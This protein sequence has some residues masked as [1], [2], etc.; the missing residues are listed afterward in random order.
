MDERLVLD[1]GK[2]Q[3]VVDRT[4]TVGRG[5]NTDIRFARDTALSRAHARF[6]PTSTGCFLE[7]LGSTNGT[8]VNGQQVTSTRRLQRGDLVRIGDQELRVGLARTEA[9]GDSHW[10]SSASN[11]G[12][13]ATRPAHLFEL[14]TRL[15]TDALAAGDSAQAERLATA[16]LQRFLADARRRDADRNLVTP[17]ARLALTLARSLGDTRWLDYV[18]ELYDELEQ[19]A[20]HALLREVLDV[21][22]ALP[23][24]S[25]L[26]VET[27]AVRHG[28][29][30]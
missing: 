26:R 11:P 23:N 14:I 8:F 5:E 4:L 27:W 12:M 28:P 15:T 17:A 25:P 18:L 13:D 2:R 20:D 22:H 6:T 19:P 7:D 21:A 29:Q 3:I 1:V 16:H 10:V 9:A 30:P 24:S